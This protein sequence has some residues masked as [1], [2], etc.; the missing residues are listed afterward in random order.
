[1]SPSIVDIVEAPAV[2]APIEVAVEAVPVFEESIVDESIVDEPIIES[3][4]SSVEYLPLNSVNPVDLPA[5]GTT[6]LRKMIF[7]TKDIIVCPGVY[8]GLSARTAIETGFDAL[9]MVCPC[10]TH[11]SSGCPV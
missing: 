10:F 11:V 9:Y 2:E 8:D 4:G 7:E 1:M 5:I 3:K 6:K